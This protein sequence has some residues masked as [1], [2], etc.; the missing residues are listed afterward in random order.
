MC[1]EMFV[2]VCVCVCVVYVSLCVCMCAFVQFPEITDEM[3]P[4]KKRKNSDVLVGYRI[5]VR[6][7]F[8][9]FK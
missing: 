2:Y 9:F 5:D 6:A 4:G 1:A 8:F 3:V 7:D